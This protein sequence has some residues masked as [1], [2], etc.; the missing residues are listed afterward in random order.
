MMTKI[1]VADDHEIVRTGLTSFIRSL[2]PH[3]DIEEAC[4]GD[5]A[6][7]K[8]RRYNYTLI[9]L[10]VTMPRTDSFGLVSNILAVKP[11]SRIL[12][13]SMNSEDVFAKRYLGMGALGYLNKDASADEIKHAIHSVMN[14]KR[15]ISP[16]LTQKLTDTALGKKAND[17]NPFD[18]LSPREF[19]IATH[20]MQGET[21]SEI[22][23]LLSLSS[24]TIGM[25]K[26]R[27]F[28]KLHC[29]NVIALNELARLHSF[30]Q[31]G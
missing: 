11:D 21:V 31:P 30:I 20:L 22:G 12:I 24:S 7:E 2:L 6:F 23:E 27:I 17:H 8:I 16:T 1:L 15:Y 25:H 28:E 29:K 26:A 19:E 9:V 3:S 18:L 4:D 5:S 10:D 14:N 13:F